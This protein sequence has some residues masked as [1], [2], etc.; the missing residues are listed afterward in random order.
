MKAKKRTVVGWGS[1]EKEDSEW[2]LLEYLHQ[3]VPVS[4]VSRGELKGG[5]RRV[6]PLFPPRIFAAAVTLKIST[7]LVP[8]IKSHLG[9]EPSA[10]F[11]PFCREHS[12]GRASFQ[13]EIT[14]K[15]FLSS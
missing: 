12:L 3:Q 5:G 11:C 6:P 2:Y 13:G 4:H 1:Q 10:D 15:L 8:V 9:T 14:P 7:Y